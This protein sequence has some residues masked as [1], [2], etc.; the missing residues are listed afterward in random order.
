MKTL[1]LWLLVIV[2]AVSQ[3]VQAQQRKTFFFG[4]NAGLNLASYFMTEDYADYYTRRKP[5]A[6]I[7]AGFVAGAAFGKMGVQSGIHFTQKGTR[8]ETENFRLNNG[9]VGYLKG[10]EKAN[11]VTIPLFFRYQFTDDKIGF[12]IAAGPSFNLAIGGS[13]RSSVHTAAG[14]SAHESGSLKFGNGLTQTYRRFQPAFGINPGVT[15]K[16][17]ESGRIGVNLLFDLG[18]N[19]LNRRRAEAGNVNGAISNIG[20]AINFT[21]VKHLPLGRN[22]N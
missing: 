11:F 1:P 13:Y 14:Q 5:V 15:F 9:G 17:G 20:T 18:F 3:P 4:G 12:F 7:T 6:G 10:W 2:A 22:E 16:A 19:A 21:Y 8:A